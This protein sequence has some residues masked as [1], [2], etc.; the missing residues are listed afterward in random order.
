[1]VTS[2][3]IGIVDG[4]QMLYR[5]AHVKGLFG[6]G[7]ENDN[8]REGESEGKIYDGLVR[9]AVQSLRNVLMANELDRCLLVYDGGISERR[10]QLAKLTG[11]EYKKS[12][13]RNPEEF[14]SEEVLR[15]RRVMEGIWSVRDELVGMLPSFGVR[16]VVLRGRE[17]DDVIGL[18]SRW[19][20]DLKLGKVVVVGDDTDFFQLLPLGVEIYRP[21]QDEVMTEGFFVERYGYESRQFLLWKSV[22]GKRGDNL[23]KVKGVGNKTIV[24]ILHE[25]GISDVMELLR[26][27]SD[28]EEGRVRRIFD[29]G[30]LVK[31]NYELSNFFCE[32]FSDKERRYLEECIGNTGGCFDEH[33]VMGYMGRY[34]FGRAGQNF[35]YFSQVFRRLL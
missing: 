9:D 27:C 19:C 26:Y 33:K 22:M 21:V 3:R 4:Q 17:A 24:R 14:D 13:L 8:D 32:E 30:F 25:S 15:A 23:G 28:S 20:V 5:V 6:D 2:L 16:V 29:E 7:G 35:E 1:M 12:P 18:L 31:M 10:R 11:E 34:Q